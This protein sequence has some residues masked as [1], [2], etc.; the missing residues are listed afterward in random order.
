MVNVLVIDV[1]GVEYKFALDRAEIVRAEK[2]GLKLKALEDTPLTQMTFLW[3]IGLHKIQPKLFNEECYELYDKY[4]AENGD[5]QEV[6]QFLSNEYGSFFQTTQQS[7]E[8][9]KKARLEVL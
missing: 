4:L 6:I 2:M 1:S 9:T 3:A 5:V 7:T 8:E